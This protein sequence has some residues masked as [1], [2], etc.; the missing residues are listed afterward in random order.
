MNVS[1]WMDFVQNIGI[2]HGD[3]PESCFFLPPRMAHAFST[4]SNDADRAALSDFTGCSK[5]EK[6]EKDEEEDNEKD[7]TNTRC[8]HFFT[9]LLFSF[10]F[11]PGGWGADPSLW[12]AWP[13]SPRFRFVSSPPEPQFS[14]KRGN[15]R[16][17]KN[18]K[19]QKI[20]TLKLHN[21]RCSK[22]KTPDFDFHILYD[23][24]YL[25]DI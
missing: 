20:S 14:K 12:G 19:F 9:R 3:F 23:L 5:N 16:L 25:S 13:A 15:Q 11:S 8:F 18:E 21:R 6:R 4:D 22:K 1:G 24:L 10:S 2:K 7:K 17:P